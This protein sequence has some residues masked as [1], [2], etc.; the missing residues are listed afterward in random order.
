MTSTTVLPSPLTNLPTSNR[1][2]R[3]RLRS[4]FIFW[5]TLL[6]VGL[7]IAG[8]MNLVSR[9]GARLGSPAPAERA[10]EWSRP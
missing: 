1:I 8:V 6:A 4:A 2:L 7:V 3:S 9:K 5:G 10:Q